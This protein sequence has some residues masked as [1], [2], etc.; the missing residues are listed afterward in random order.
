[1]TRVLAIL[2]ALSAQIGWAQQRTVLRQALPRRLSV[3][4]RLGRAN[5]AD[6]RDTGVQADT[7]AQL[8]GGRDAHQPFLA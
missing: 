1:M 3:A 6:D 5:V 2:L 7:D 8:A 4:A